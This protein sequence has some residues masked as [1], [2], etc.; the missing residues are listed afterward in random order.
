MLFFSFS[1][2]LQPLI[3]FLYAVAFVC[4]PGG[5]GTMDEFFESMTLIQTNKV[6]PF[7]VVLMGSAFWSPLVD[8]MRVHQLGDDPYI[9]P[10]DLDLFR[11]IDDV[12]EAVALIVDARKRR[13]QEQATPAE[14]LGPRTAEGTFTGRQP[15]RRGD[16]RPYEDLTR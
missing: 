2:F 8:W 3:F 16:R 9:S 6:E 14:S 1:L 12:D 10:E 5:F 4:F 15:Q 7:P 11:I 13:A